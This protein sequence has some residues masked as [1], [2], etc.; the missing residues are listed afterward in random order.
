MFL[1]N[2]LSSDGCDMSY[3]FRITK[4]ESTTSQL[5]KE[6]FGIPSVCWPLF[7]PVCTRIPQTF[8]LEPIYGWKI[9]F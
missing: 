6:L 7:W 1:Y 2:T 3:E 5:L 8:N 4:H 9:F